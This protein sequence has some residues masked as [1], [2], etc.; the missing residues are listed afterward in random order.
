MITRAVKI[1]IA[2]AEKINA[3]K[4]CKDVSKCFGHKYS[5]NY[6][7]QSRCRIHIATEDQVNVLKIYEKGKLI[8][9]QRY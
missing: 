9:E 1:H 7:N 4:I 5:K 6:Y 3:Y 2:I 8:C